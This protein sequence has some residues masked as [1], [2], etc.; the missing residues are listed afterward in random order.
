[1]PRRGYASQHFKGRVGGWNILLAPSLKKSLQY[2]FF[3]DD[4]WWILSE[5]TLKKGLK[6]CI[7]SSSKTK[8]SYPRGR[9]PLAKKKALDPR[10]SLAQLALA[11]L[12]SLA[13]LPGLTVFPKPTISIL[14]IMIWFMINKSS[15]NQ[16][17][18]AKKSWFQWFAK[19]LD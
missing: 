15:P 16:L 14:C 9:C 7:F 10:K 8:F 4:L 5:F 1:M 6:L 3:H 12:A 18:W 17:I 2:P 19:N 13:H 11:L